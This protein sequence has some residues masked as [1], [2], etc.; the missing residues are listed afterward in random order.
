MA[1]SRP[2]KE[3]RRALPLS[4]PLSL[5]QPGDRWCELSLALCSRVASQAPQHFRSSDVSHL[6]LKAVK[7]NERASLKSGEKQANKQTNTG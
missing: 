5:S 2:F 4:T 6:A 1:L 7:S 3:D